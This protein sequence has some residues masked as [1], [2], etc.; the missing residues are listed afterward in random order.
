MILRIILLSC[1]LALGC[2]ALTAGEHAVR[3]VEIAV[4]GGGGMCGGPGQT[5]GAEWISQPD[6][7]SRLPLNGNRDASSYPWDPAV[8]GLL[9][10]HMG[11]QLTGGYGIE[12]AAP[13]A[14]VR[15]AVATIR[16]N[17][18]EPEPGSM[19]TQ[20]ITAPCLLLRMPKEGIDQI[21]VLDQHGFVLFEV[22]VGS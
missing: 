21:V 6:Q 7:K 18:I 10:I 2:S 12:P 19:V 9:L 20:A 16:V 22:K 5:A 11:A 13:V 8:D 14:T 3:E 1:V 15:K 17:W 4:I